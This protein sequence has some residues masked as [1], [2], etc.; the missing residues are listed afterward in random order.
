MDESV[1]Q[2]VYNFISAGDGEQM[3]DDCIRHELGLTN[4]NQV[5]QITSVLG[6]TPL[7]V[8]HHDLCISCG[9]GKLIIEKVA[10]N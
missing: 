9:R 8:R 6:V 2:R 3:C 10:P 4:R 5:S 7:F 1:P